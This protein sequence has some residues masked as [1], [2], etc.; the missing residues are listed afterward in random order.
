MMPQQKYQSLSA[1]LV[2]PPLVHPNHSPQQHYPAYP[3]HVQPSTSNGARHPQREEEEEEE[4]DDEVVEEELD[5]RDH[6]SPSVQSPP[7]SSG[8]ANKSTP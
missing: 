5:A 6:G 3:A 7:L 8:L 2:G 4:D 1:A